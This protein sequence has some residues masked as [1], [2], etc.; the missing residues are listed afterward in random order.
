MFKN[1]YKEKFNW[2]IL[3]I[4]TSTGF[5]TGVYRN[6]IMTLFPILQAE[7]ALNRTQIGLY[8]TFLFITMTI[9]T[10]FAGQIADQYGVKRS[11]SWGLIFLGFFTILHSVASNYTLLMLFATL[12]G[13][14]LSIILPSTSKAVSEWF[15][16]NYKSTAMGIMTMGFAL[17][18]VAG[19][20]L[21]PWTGV[22]L[23]WRSSLII[24]GALFFLI[25]IIFNF[26]YK[27]KTVKTTP[28]NGK[29]DLTKALIK[30]IK[31]FFRSKY[32]IMLS[33]LG[34]IFG[35]FSGTVSTHFS[36]FLYSEYGFTEVAAGIGFMILQIGS[37]FGR[38]SWGVLDDRLTGKLEHKGFLLIG[39][40]MSFLSL[41]FVFLHNFNPSL[42]I[43]LFF[44]FLL[45]AS[46][47]GWHGLY[48]SEVSNQLGEKHTGMG[49]GLSLF[50]VHL[51]IIIGPPLF[52]YI[53]DCA[54]TYSF[55][56]LFLSIIT[57]IP[58]LYINHFISKYYK[59]QKT[60]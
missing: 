55:S 50:F 42:F 30:N 21:L 45:G 53:A 26:T 46:G 38:T 60:K 20:S 25:A 3:L 59:M 40:T 41:I 29:T 51:G 52:G 56:W 11:I 15:K 24:L 48:F 8:S 37:M 57:I 27:N 10:I 19:S 47:R 13:L 14:G 33:F 36:Y 22:N 34:L 18:G 54:D 23:G 7:F 16:G 43:I 44:A 35:I 17:G 1:K 4:I 32:L 2:N 12:N 39:F 31:K 49:V 9:I 6:G 5:I 58:I 28:S